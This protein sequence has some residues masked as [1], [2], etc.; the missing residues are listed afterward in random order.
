MMINYSQEKDVSG[1]QY[2]AQY[3]NWGNM[4]ALWKKFW[5]CKFHVEDGKV[6][7]I[8][9]RVLDFTTI[10]DFE[11]TLAMVVYYF[12]EYTCYY[13]RGREYIQNWQKKILPTMPTVELTPKNE[14]LFIEVPEYLKDKRTERIVTDKELAKMSASDWFVTYK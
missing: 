3:K 4:A 2:F 12:P 10:P 8:D 9:F 5:S 1:N 13:R 7:Q 14:T 11:N 6:K